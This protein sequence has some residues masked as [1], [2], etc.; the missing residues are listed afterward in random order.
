MR[1]YEYHRFNGFLEVPVYCHCEGMK[2]CSSVRVEI[3][4][5]NRL[6]LRSCQSEF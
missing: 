2:A 5:N 1:N 4:Y 3:G 6:G